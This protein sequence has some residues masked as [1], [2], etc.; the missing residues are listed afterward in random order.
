MRRCSC[1]RRRELHHGQVIGV[2]GGMLCAVAP[3]LGDARASFRRRQAARI[4]G[5]MARRGAGG[6]YGGWRCCGA[7]LSVWGRSFS[8]AVNVVM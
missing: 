8:R 1:S 3:V 2:D 5:E 4:G 6:I 7:L